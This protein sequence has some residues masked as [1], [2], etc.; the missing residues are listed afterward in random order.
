MHVLFHTLLWPARY[1][2]LLAWLFSLPSC[3][4]NKVW[5]PRVLRLMLPTFLRA[6][7][8]PANSETNPLHNSNSRGIRRDLG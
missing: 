7:L 6:L 2:R 4:P 5:V 3:R 8:T 1:L